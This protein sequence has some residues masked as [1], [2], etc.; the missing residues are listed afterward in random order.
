M[1]PIKFE[2]DSGNILKSEVKHGITNV[3]AESIFEDEKKLVFYDYKH[4]ADEIRY[5]CLGKS[6]MGRI[7]YIVYHHR[8]SKVRIISV[9]VAGDKNKNLYESQ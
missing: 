3:E 9:R 6:F 4:S 2:Y 5:I 8:K 1:P 7:L